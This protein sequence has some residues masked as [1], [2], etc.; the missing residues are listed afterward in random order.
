MR[1]EECVTFLQWALPRLH[2]RWSGFRRVRRQVCRRVD[3]RMRALHLTDIDAYR[4]HLER[5]PDEWAILDGLCRI[6]ISVFYRD[7]AV[8]DFL[9][10]AVLPALSQQ[11]RERHEPSMRAWSIG[12]ASGEEPYTLLLAW[13]LG[14]SVPMPGIGL[15]ILATDV[16]ATVLQR[17]ATA[18][19]PSS[20]IKLLPPAW[21]AAAFDRIDGRY[22]LREP[23]RTGVR[24]ERQDVR[25]ALPDR[26][27]DL[28]LC[29]NL[30][31]TYFDA[32][33]QRET[34]GRLLARLR[35]GGAF[36][37]GRREALPEGSHL[38]AWRGDLGVYRLPP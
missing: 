14:R 10:D 6:T 27:F 16:D 25:T 4:A 9:A 26:R 37:I 28:I 12:C 15:D 13:R 33:L 19:Y 36:V 21:S 35:P 7:K 31:F 3:A 1:D 29:R 24:F 11:A 18:C 23:Y 34:L 38:A 5:R 22:C 8:F 17:A 20:S 32:A 30:A 2:L